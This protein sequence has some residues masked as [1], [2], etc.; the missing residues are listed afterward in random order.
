MSSPWWMS[1]WSRPF[2]VCFSFCTIWNCQLVVDIVQLIRSPSSLRRKLSSVYNHW[3]LLDLLY[4][5][6][7]KM[8]MKMCDRK[9]YFIWPSIQNQYHNTSDRIH[10][11]GHNHLPRHCCNCRENENKHSLKHFQTINK[12]QWAVN[13]F[14]VLFW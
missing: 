14:L 7:E 5:I 8:N 10:E 1:P 9:Q 4:L 6:I 12:V 3:L 13:K 11:L 2:S